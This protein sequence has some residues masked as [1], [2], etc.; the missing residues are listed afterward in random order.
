VHTV[1]KHTSPNSLSRAGLRP[2]RTR[3]AK[4]DAAVL[5]VGKTSAIKGSR[6][7]LTYHF[8]DRECTW[9]E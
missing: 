8:L 9:A 5:R 2:S 1:L 3:I 4:G 7:V 6:Q